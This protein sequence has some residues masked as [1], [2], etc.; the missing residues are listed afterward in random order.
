MSEKYRYVGKRVFAAGDCSHR[1]C[2]AGGLHEVRAIVEGGS[3]QGTYRRSL[4]F[5]DP[6]FERFCEKVGLFAPM[7]S[8]ASLAEPK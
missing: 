2:S 1:G 3:R 6:C 4:F 5:C 7:S 8:P